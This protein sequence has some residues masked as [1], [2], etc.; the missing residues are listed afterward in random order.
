MADGVEKTGVLILVAGPSGSG[1]DTL[2]SAARL[3]LADNPA[4]VFPS[5]LITRADKT[6]EDHIYMPPADFEHARAQ[7]LFFLA[8]EAHGFSYGIPAS[9]QSDLTAGRTA[10]VNV[11]RRLIPAAR[12]LWRPTHAVI[13]SARPAALRERLLI[14]GRETEAEIEARVRRANDE[15]CSIEEPVHFL[16]NS[17]PLRDAIEQFL[18]LLLQLNEPVPAQDLEDPAAIG[19]A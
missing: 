10:V 5:R 14:R 18:A 3:A 12:S 11:S 13:I 15:T 19:L 1:K 7:K 8:W 6:G 16:D 2:I 17:G 4:F 9:V